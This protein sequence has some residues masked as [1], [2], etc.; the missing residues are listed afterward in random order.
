LQ[1]FSVIFFGGNF[2]SFSK[3]FDVSQTL[4]R[5]RKHCPAEKVAEIKGSATLF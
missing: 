5:R 2:K 1:V 4:C 3:Q